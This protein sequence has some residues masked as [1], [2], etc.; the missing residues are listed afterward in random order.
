VSVGLTRRAIKTTK[1][2]IDVT[3]VSRIQVPVHVEE[4]CAT[5]LPAANAISQLAQ[6]GQVVSCK[7]SQA[8]RKGQSFATFNLLGNGG[9]YSVM[10]KIHE[11]VLSRAAPPNVTRRITLTKALVVKNAALSLLKSLDLMS[12]CW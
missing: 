1:L 5:V 12:R 11:S 8:V 4:G 10:G 2:A 7:Q 6:R 9:Q 3:N